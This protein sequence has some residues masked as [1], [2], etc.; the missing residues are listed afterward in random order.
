MIFQTFS[1]FKTNRSKRHYSY[2]STICSWTLGFALIV[3]RSPSLG[4]NRGG[5]G[6]FTG[7]G[8][9]R[10]AGGGEWRGSVE[11]PAHTRRC[12][13]LAPQRFEAR[14]PR[15]QAHGG[16]G[17]RVA[18]LYSGEGRPRRGMRGPGEDDGA[19][20]GGY[21]AARR[22]EVEERRRPSLLAVATMAAARGHVERGEKKSWEWR[23]ESSWCSTTWSAAQGTR[24]RV[25]HAAT[26]EARGVHAR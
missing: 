13:R 12:Q 3:A 9:R 1:Q 16:H 5:G 7:A 2:E 23:G 21:R 19:G 8:R 11:G 22:S 18:T 24:Q 20:D 6:G 14:W 10:F 15:E 4:Q 26:T 17:C 25:G